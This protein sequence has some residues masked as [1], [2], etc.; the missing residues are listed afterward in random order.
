MSL[1]A[2]IRAH[3][4]R[5]PYLWYA[6]LSIFA[7]LV[8]HYRLDFIAQRADEPTRTV[9]ALEMMFSGN[10]ITPTI[11]GEWY[12][13]KPPF[14]NWLLIALMKLTG[15]Q[16]DF[17]L[18]LPSSAV[19]F[20]FGYTIFAH[21]KRYLGHAK[22]FIAAAMFVTCGRMLIYA[23][24]LGHIDVFYSWITYLAFIVLFE[25]GKKEA[26]FKALFFSYLL[27][28]VAFLCKG[29]P[30]VLFAGLS[31]IAVL[32]Y[33]R[34]LAFV[35]NWR[36]LLSAGVFLGIIGGYF[37]VYSQYNSLDGWIDQLWDQSA[38]RT[39]ADSKHNWFDAIL[40]I[41]NFPIDHIKHLA[42]WSLFFPLLFFKGFW[43]RVKEQELLRIFGLIFLVNIPVYW[44]SPGVYPRYLFM[45]YPL[46]FLFLSDRLLDLEDSGYV[47]F[48]DKV[49]KVLLLLLALLPIAAL[50]LPIWGSYHEVKIAICVVLGLLAYWLY[51]KVIPNRWW[52]LTL[53]LIVLR[54]G[55]NFFVLEQRKVEDRHN[56]YMLGAI[57]AAKLSGD[58][59]L[60]LYYYTSINHGTTFYIEREKQAIL[61]NKEYPVSGEF[62][63][64]DDFKKTQWPQEVEF[65]DIYQFRIRYNQQFITLRKAL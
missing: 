45:L 57:E 21:A 5:H 25:Y 33:Y 54:L 24:L 63:L 38:Q 17:L 32:W 27:H 59:P 34:N 40:S 48:W 52:S 37:F 18:R 10:Y 26:W 53:V 28:A 64:L 50:W 20:L 31:S 44:L 55:F 42:P 56:T 49:F 1:A 46:V 15:S 6:G 30:S 13:R 19:L 39:V 23:S 12:Y 4:E 65:E 58:K 35:F 3:Y 11:N 7:F 2:Q 36:H 29:L 14:Y 61:R 51:I 60:Y 62:Y 43:K 8:Y 22:A 9:V 41:F 16:S 47:R